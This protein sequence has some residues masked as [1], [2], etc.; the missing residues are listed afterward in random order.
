[1]D[2]DLASDSSSS[3]E[4]DSDAELLNPQVEAKF[5]QIVE[6]IRRNDPKLKESDKPL[7]DDEDFEDVKKGNSSA[8]ADGS[9][10]KAMTLKD[11]IRKHTLKKM[12]KESDKDS[13]S[14]NDSESSDGEQDNSKKRR[15]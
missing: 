11:Q 7:F 4:E 8:A 5:L 1:M 10:I 15:P 3:S 2:E 12:D 13:E 9:K 14:D 6:A